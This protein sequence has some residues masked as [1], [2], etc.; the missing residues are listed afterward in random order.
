MSGRIIKAFLVLIF[1]CG[2]MLTGKGSGYF[3]WN[4]A[5]PPEAAADSRLYYVEELNA[6]QNKFINLVDGYSISLPKEMKII[7]FIPGISA[8]LE[9]E[10][11]RVEIYKQSTLNGVSGNA[12]INYSNRFL[13]NQTD[14]MQVSSEFLTWKGMRLNV[15]QWSR[16]KL[17]KV[18]ND[19]NHYAC[20]DIM[21]RDAVY[22]FFIKSDLPI[23]DSS[24]YMDLINNFSAFAPMSQAIIEKYELSPQK[25]W[26]SETADF[27][28]RYFAA[29]SKLTWGI[30]EPSAPQEMKNLQELEQ[31]ME[32]DFPFILLYTKV[33]ESYDSNYVGESLQRAYENGKTVELTLQTTPT[34]ADSHNMVYDILNG[35]Y[36]DFLRAYAQDVADFDHPVL[37]RPFNEMNGDWCVYSAYYT[38]RDTYLFRELY[39]YI[40]SIFEDAGADNVI[41]VWNPNEKSFPD[42]KWNNEIMY[43]PGSQYVDVVGLTGYNTGTYY[44]GEKW[45]SFTDI[46]LPLYQKSF[47]Y[48]KPMMITEFA[49]S[50]IG[51][52][53]EQWVE[54]M[55][56]N[57][58]F[59]P[60]IKI[61]IWWDGCDFDAS[62][63]IAR[64]YFIDETSELID[65]FR[66]NLRQYK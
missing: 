48:N 5:Q 59:Y 12:Y 37:F 31:K 61:A 26:N 34:D 2:L 50:S 4:D 63:N 3:L 52:S 62:G 58:G 17:L 24:G 22:T 42:F 45:R 28:A 46:Y 40:Y 27:F 38:S 60:H 21:T 53:K 25:N 9:E 35:R 65:I 23:K 57:I 14:H 10:H 19:K 64:P 36:D 13:N 49:C 11:R 7:D 56:N 18:K 51:S 66:E 32:Y 33:K 16:E 39:K 8:V 15:A 55:F 6:A 54:D 41:W 1:V 43:Y 20:V 29:D 44:N 30:F 47:L